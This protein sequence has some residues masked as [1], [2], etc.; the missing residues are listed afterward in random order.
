MV[1]LYVEIFFVSS[2][3]CAPRT[4]RLYPLAYALSVVTFKT[5]I[6]NEFI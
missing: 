2:F 1:I 3:A 5:E 4:P 6:S